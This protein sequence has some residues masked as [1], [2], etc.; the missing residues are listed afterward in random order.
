MH[1]TCISD[2]GVRLI[3][4]TSCISP[5]RTR[6]AGGPPSGFMGHPVGRSWDVFHARLHS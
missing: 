3:R 4:S 5:L 1:H 6:E 2:Q